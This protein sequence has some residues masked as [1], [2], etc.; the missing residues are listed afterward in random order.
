MM[1]EL[2][3]LERDPTSPCAGRVSRR[4][5]DICLTEQGLADQEG[6]RSWVTAYP[7]TKP[8]VNDAMK[9]LQ[10]GVK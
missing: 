1:I 3:V 10:S 4:K 9:A 2:G 6:F 5:V 7:D 8:S